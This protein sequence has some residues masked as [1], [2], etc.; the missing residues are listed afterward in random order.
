LI[1]ASIPRLHETT[2]RP[3]IVCTDGVNSTTELR[4]RLEE[5]HAV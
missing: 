4:V 5:I 3:I 1:F 2:V